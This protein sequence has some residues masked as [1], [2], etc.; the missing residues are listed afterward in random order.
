MM[1]LTILW[2]MGIGLRYAYIDSVIRAEVIYILI[3]LSLV[4]NL[5]FYRQKSKSEATIVLQKIGL[6]IL[7]VLLGFGHTQ[8]YIAKYHKNY[9]TNTI[10]DSSD[11]V[12]KIDKFLSKTDTTQKFLA[13]IKSLSSENYSDGY[14]LVYLKSREDLGIHD[15]ILLQHIQLQ[16]IPRSMNPHQFDLKS[17]YAYKN[18][19]HRTFIDA[20]QIVKLRRADK[21]IAGMA[22]EASMY[23]RNII[24]DAVG[25]KSISAVL[26]G[27]LLGLDDEID[28]KT[29]S[30]YAATGAAHILSVSG[31]HVGLILGL[32]SLLLGF[33]DKKKSLRLLKFI[34]ISI[35]L[36]S[37]AM[38]CGMGSSIMRAVLMCM[39]ILI[40][41]LFFKQIQ[42]VNILW[43]VAFILMI[44]DPGVLFDIGFQL[45][46]MAVLGIL[47][48]YPYVGRWYV[49]ENKLL[50]HL[51]QSTAVSICAQIPTL[52]II[53]YYFHNL[54]FIALVGNII[55]APLSMII[56]YG[57]ILLLL[58]HRV[59]ILKNVVVL[60][61]KKSV[62]AMNMGL[63]FL[64]LPSITYIDDVTLS[65]IQYG[66]VYVL[67]FCLI[68]YFMYR[69]KIFLKI[70][71][72]AV[73]VCILYE[74]I[75]DYNMYRKTELICYSINEG[76]AIDIKDKGNLYIIRQDVEWDEVNFKT[77]NNRK[78]YA[79]VSTN[80]INSDTLIGN[81]LYLK[82]E[83]LFYKGKI[84]SLNHYDE[85][86]DLNIL[87]YYKKGKDY[88][89]TIYLKG[90]KQNNTYVCN[91]DGAYI[92]PL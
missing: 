73:A 27:I 48:L 45:S 9:F 20:T 15:E 11:V 23:F 40:G 19:F 65:W 76:I 51:W 91:K 13:Q 41:K 46:F 79:A 6:L 88:P 44:W 12:M 38:I 57:T 39:M 69:E 42:T 18:I 85:N 52:P 7:I 5:L 62:L 53:M 54:T 58:V 16:E 60:I 64:V 8:S 25:D 3:G 63:N 75:D 74:M 10:T 71:L 49:S 29:R 66:C 80:L 22:Y 1:L 77:N 70:S 34:L 30:V 89:K 26:T 84:I 61:L 2:A 86:A 36:L 82:E 17:Y 4:I 81:K 14:V 24:Y 47:V 43:S 35:V 56:L 37:Y 83:M 32:L 90:K 72:S 67:I 78:Y 68:L 55:A 50:G 87:S 59:T 31:M 33:M 92:L 28:I 21:S